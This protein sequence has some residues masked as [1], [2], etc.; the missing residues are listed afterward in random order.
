LSPFGV[1]VGVAH[2]PTIT[3]SLKMILRALKKP[4]LR[5]TDRACANGA[6]A[7]HPAKA[8]ASAADHRRNMMQH[9]L[10]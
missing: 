1:L 10:L 4:I 5:L 6:V 8:D 3:V 9:G 7:E 2:A